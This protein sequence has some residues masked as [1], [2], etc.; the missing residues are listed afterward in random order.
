[1]QSRFSLKSLE[2]LEAR[3]L[4]VIMGLARPILEVVSG[5]NLFFYQNSLAA[6]LPL[7]V[8]LHTAEV[9][10]CNEKKNKYFS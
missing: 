3:W 8:E 9:L 6:K 10:L 1:M 4:R 5:T 2:D 7:N